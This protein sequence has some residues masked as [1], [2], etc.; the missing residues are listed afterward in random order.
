MIKALLRDLRARIKLAVDWTP[1]PTILMYHSISKNQT[2]A[3]VSPE[4]FARQMRWIKE[5]GWTIVPL[6]E[7]VRRAL[8]GE[9]GK[10]CALTFDDGYKD[11]LTEAVPVLKV[12]GFPATVFL[13]AGMMGKDLRSSDGDVAPLMTWEDARACLRTPGITVGSHTMTHAKLPKFS[14][15]KVRQEL[16]ASRDAI[17]KE[18]GCDR[19]MWFCYPKGRHDAATA[20]Q[21]REQGYAGAVTVV[22]GHPAADTNR[23]VIP[24]GLVYGTMS[25]SEFRAL[26]V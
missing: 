5:H 26:F 25:D 4:I 7:C 9:K 23:F 17:V 21:V 2:F 20:Q 24:R 10:F 18:L 12:H 14:A 1:R 6:E 19:A 22:P 13:I 8:A 3:T 11:F 16:S 15:E